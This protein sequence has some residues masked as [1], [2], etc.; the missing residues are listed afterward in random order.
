MVVLRHP[1]SHTLVSRVKLSP[2]LSFGRWVPWEKNARV[3]NGGF[4][5]S[6]DW[7][8][9]SHLAA[10]P[11][12]SGHRTQLR[13]CCSIQLWPSSLCCRTVI[14]TSFGLLTTL[15]L[16]AQKFLD[17]SK[18]M[19]ALFSFRSILTC[20]YYIRL[21]PSN[22]YSDPVMCFELW[23]LRDGEVDQSPMGGGR[24]VWIPLT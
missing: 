24:K 9:Q 21:F 6:E 22:I 1:T 2:H 20:L 17:S 7:E 16:D 13:P 18:S 8:E 14:Q 3:K 11:V 4:M 10:L 5:L 19:C 12:F 15:L 23:A